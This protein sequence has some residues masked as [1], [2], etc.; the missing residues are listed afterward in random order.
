MML[1]SSNKTDKLDARGMNRLQRTGTLP[2]VWIPHSELRDTRELFRTRMVLSRQRVQ[3]KNRIHATLAKYGLR[4][5][6]TSDIFNRKGRVAMEHALA[7]LPL[8][9]RFSVEQLLDELDGVEEK[10]SAFE[11]R[12]K[13]VFAD[14]QDA[15]LLRTIP[16]VGAILSV[17]IASEV[18]D[19]ARFPSSAHLAAYA[20]TTPRVSAS[21]GKYRHG[22]APADTNH[23]LKW[24]Y[25]EAANMLMMTRHRSTFHHLN[26][27]YERVRSRKGHS[28]AIG[29]V[30]RHLAEATWAI[31]TKRQPYR[32]PSQRRQAVSS[33]SG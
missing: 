1:A 25:A 6:N 9:T 20:G 19:V 2:T 5:D 13:E 3:L 4:I 30:S 14:S 11:H 17:V 10:I 8:Q 31:L 22:R 21:G 28:V 27:V 16:G 18:G 7:K 23:Y 12:I 26:A 15:R 29:A 32:E 33:T 24:A